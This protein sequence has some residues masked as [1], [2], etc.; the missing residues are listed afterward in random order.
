MSLRSLTVT[1]GAVLLAA[2]MVAC[3]QSENTETYD[4]PADAAATDETARMDDTPDMDATAGTAGEAMTSV[5]DIKGEPGEFVG[6]TVTVEAE[7]DRVVGPFA[8]YLDEEAP[9]RAGVDNDL[10]VLVKK[11]GDTG[12]AAQAGQEWG[13]ERV[14]VTGK[15]HEVSVV[16]VEREIGWDLDPE[17]EAE[18]EDRDAVLIAESVRP[19]ER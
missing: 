8:F 12:T 9:L 4:R 19:I 7:V 11:A 10:L 14:R 2:T 18:L 17:I 1:A 16:E 6:R 3:G 13:D 5:A 15:V